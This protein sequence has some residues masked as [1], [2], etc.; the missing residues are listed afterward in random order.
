MIITKNG[1]LMP[2]VFLGSP[3]HIM[4]VVLKREERHVVK[5]QRAKRPSV[6]AEAASYKLT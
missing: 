2:K 3:G 6:E 1:S 4:Y 5:S